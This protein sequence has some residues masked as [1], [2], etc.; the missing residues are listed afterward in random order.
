MGTIST[1]ASSHGRMAR[2]VNTKLFPGSINS[3]RRGFTINVDLE[4]RSVEE[5]RGIFNPD[6]VQDGRCKTLAIMYAGSTTSH[7][8]Y[9]DV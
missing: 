4:E 3:R 7:A 9:S 5:L 6:V 8:Q 1:W 2:T